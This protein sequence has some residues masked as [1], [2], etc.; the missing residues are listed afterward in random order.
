MNPLN[1]KGRRN[2]N[3]NQWLTPGVGNQKL[4]EHLGGV[5]VLERIA[6]N[7]RTF[8]SSIQRA[9]PKPGEQT[10]MDIEE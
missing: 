3:N 4:Q 10:E 6:P 5:S 1:K 9:F 2:V 7:R 8:Y